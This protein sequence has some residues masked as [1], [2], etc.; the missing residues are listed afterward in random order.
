MNQNF[1]KNQKTVKFSAGEATELEIPGVGKV[2]FKLENNKLSASLNGGEFQT[3]GFERKQVRGQYLKPYQIDFYKEISG[4]K[5]R[6]ARLAVKEQG[7]KYQ[8]TFSTYP[9]AETNMRRYA[10]NQG[11]ELTH[12]GS[13][14]PTCYLCA[15]AHEEHKTTFGDLT[16]ASPNWTPLGS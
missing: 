15:V 1:T 4:K 16:K 10:I 8:A 9:H 11:L 7:E 6:V 12:S 13:D 14:K 5:V 3:A 2:Q